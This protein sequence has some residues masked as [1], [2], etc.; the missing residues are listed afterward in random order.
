M[1]GP[2]P[3][4]VSCTAKRTNRVKFALHYL[5]IFFKPDVAA[6]TFVLCARAF[7]HA[8]SPIPLTFF[9]IHVS[10]T[11]S[12]PNNAYAKCENLYRTLKCVKIT[13]SNG[14]RYQGR[15]LGSELKRVQS[16][17]IVLQRY[18][19]GGRHTS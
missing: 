6:V 9:H 18:R 5:E 16:D 2:P 13:N 7:A 15:K 19:I 11:F 3:V 4:I 12:L 10:H 14:T 17:R 1:F 8:A